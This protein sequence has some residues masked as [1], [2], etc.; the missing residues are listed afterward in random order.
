MK[1][2]LALEKVTMNSLVLCPYMVL[3]AD[4]NDVNILTISY[5]GVL[6]EKPPMIGIA[7]RPGRYSHGLLEKSGEFTLNLPSQEMLSDM[8]YCGTFSG[9]TVDKIFTRKMEL[10]SSI[11]VK[12]P[13]L[14]KS[15]ISLE[16]K[17]NR[18][19]HLSKEGASHDY[20]IADV[21]AAH[22]AEGFSLEKSELVVTTNFDYRLVE[23]TLGKAFSVWKK[24]KGG[25]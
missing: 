24:K 11:Y 15:P 16:C 22:K 19:L 4:E 2:T 7:V 20:F 13:I 23:K 21:L 3:V 17:I 18:I 14:E 6:S 1:K 5:V 9:K 12:T 10:E 8:D 25:G